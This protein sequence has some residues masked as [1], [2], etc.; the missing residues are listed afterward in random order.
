VLKIGSHTG[1][2]KITSGNEQTSLTEEKIRGIV[3]PGVIS[4]KR[5]KEKER[6]QGGFQ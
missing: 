1:E 6:G 5:K 3:P 4:D 2:G